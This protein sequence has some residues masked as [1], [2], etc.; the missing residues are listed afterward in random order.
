MK[1][2]KKIPVF[3]TKS[4]LWSSRSFTRE[5]YKELIH[6][7]MKEVGKYGLK[8]THNWFKQRSNFQ[9]NQTYTKL[10]RNT[11]AWKQY[12]I[13]EAYKCIN[14]VIFEESESNSENRF[15]VTGYFYFYLNYTPIVLKHKNNLLSFPDVR[16]G[17]YHIFLYLALAKELSLYS[18]VNKCRQKGWTYKLGAIAMVDFWLKLKQRI[19]IFTPTANNMKS[20]WDDVVF[21]NINFLEVNTGWH[22][23]FQY[24]KAKRYYD[25][26]WKSKEGGKEVRVGRQNEL[27]GILTAKES[28]SLVGGYNTM[29]IGDEVGVNPKLAEQ[30]TLVE[31]SIRVGSFMSGNLIIGGS[32]GELDQCKDLRDIT[33]NPREH[34]FLGVPDPTDPSKER[35]PFIAT[36]WNYIGGEKNE[37]GEVVNPLKFYDEDGNSDIEGALEEINKE[38]ELVKQ[39]GPEKYDAFCSQNP[40][41]IDEMYKVTGSNIFPPSK[42]L[43]QERWLFENYST[44]DKTYEFDLQSDS[45]IPIRASKSIVT[46]FPLKSGSYREGAIVIEE[47]PVSD[48]PFI[49]YAGV[50]PVK[51]LM[52]R[53]ESLMSC[54]IYQS[55]YQDGGEMKG[56]KVVA[57]FT[58]RYKDDEDTYETVRR[59]CKY[60]NARTGIES[61]EGGF[62]EWMKGK[63]EHN[64]MLKRSQFP[65][66]K[67]LV[68]NSSISDEYGIRMNTGGHTMSRVKTFIFTSIIEYINE[69]LDTY[70]LGDGTQQFMY[71]VERIKDIMALREMLT[72]DGSGNYDR[73]ISLG[74]AI[75]TGRAYET[76]QIMQRVNKSQEQKPILKTPNTLINYKRLTPSIGLKAV[77]GFNAF[78]KRQ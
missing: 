29:I 42:I 10:V 40:I 54:H 72:Y 19:K 21:S 15:Y 20:I 14:G 73:L 38:R 23:N 22:R 33:Y 61:D 32:V 45:I 78:K 59:L 36:Q 9:K 50:D 51:N 63:K 62:I 64:L 7:S 43:R 6:S 68:P 52:N 2:Y 31:P 1:A 34:K 24:D 69:K 57:W 44:N 11:K 41:S 4:K 65:F 35:L 8:D 67:D 3:N 75:A 27:F 77:T 60:Y 37:K 13:K 66:L 39:Q 18:G 76:A 25:M 16:D 70:T 56:G 71:G 46:D 58:G 30:I 28:T 12:W 49:Y 55:L 5:Q 26:T 17:D 47:H 48:R 74:I 53:G